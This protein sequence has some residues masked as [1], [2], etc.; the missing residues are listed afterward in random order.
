MESDR[1]RAESG[2]PPIEVRLFGQSRL[3]R[4]GA[5]LALPEAIFWMVW[6]S[7]AALAAHWAV[8]TEPEGE[9]LFREGARRVG[10]T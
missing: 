9:A 3:C 5:T 7:T 8:K 10:V 1:Q 6:R 4:Y 2:S